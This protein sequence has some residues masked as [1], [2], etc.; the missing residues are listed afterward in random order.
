[1]VGLRR[2]RRWESVIFTELFRRKMSGLLPEAT[3]AEHASGR[4]LQNQQGSFD[5]KKE[6]D[7]IQSWLVVT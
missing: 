5:K 4:E 7:F 2:L 3:M 6:S 1:M